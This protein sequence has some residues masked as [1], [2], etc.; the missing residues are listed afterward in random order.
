M[1]GTLDDLRSVELTFRVTSGLRPYVDA[2]VGGL[3]VRLMVHAN[4]SF[5]AMVTHD[6]ARRAGL[7]LGPAVRDGYGISAVGRLG[8]RGRTTATVAALRVGPD[9]APDVAL[10]VFDVPQDPPVDGM[11]GLGWLRERAVA[12]DLGAGRLR[13][14]AGPPA[15]GARVVP[16]AWDEE[17]GAYVVATTVDGRPARFVVSTVAGV[18]VDAVAA[19]RFGLER[20]RPLGDDGGPTGTVVASSAVAG[21]WSVGLG[22]AS[23]PVAGGSVMDLYAYAEQERPEPGRAVDGFLGCDFLLTYQAVVDVAGERLVLPA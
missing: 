1:T 22:G 5:T 14:G 17:W 9:V 23:Y 12:V 6:V 2:E 13:F 18:V 20:G 21:G 15:P 7:A 4:A 3:P 8:G 11:L 16:M 10:A 19:D